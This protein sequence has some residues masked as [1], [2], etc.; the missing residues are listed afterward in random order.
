M[1][2]FLSH[3]N[4]VLPLQGLSLP[5]PPFR[6]SIPNRLPRLR[7]LLSR[8]ARARLPGLLPGILS[9]PRLGDQLARDGEKWFSRM[10]SSLPEISGACS[11]SSMDSARVMK[12]LTCWDS[13]LKRSTSFL[14][15]FESTI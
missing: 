1:N 7:R 2:C 9:Q 12:S 5:L 4:S 10:H 8:P 14:C 15:I 3:R 11:R 6:R 13:P